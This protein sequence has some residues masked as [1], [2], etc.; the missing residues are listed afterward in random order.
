MATRLGRLYEEDF[1]AW[2][3]DQA[4]ALRRLAQARPNDA[5]DFVHLVEEV[6]DL[7][8]SE[9]DT[10]R[11]HVRT[12]IEHLLKLEHSA[13]REPRAG[14]T[15]SITHA[16][17]A[18]QDKLTPS[19]RRDLAANLDRLYEQARRQASVAMSVHGEAAA[20]AAL[21]SA[22]PYTLEHILDDDWL[23]PDPHGTD[24]RIGHRVG[25]R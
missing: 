12:I 17:I 24:A 15:I 13:A 10:V 23:P 4:K 21:P 22:W 14:W 5:V 18:L 6:Q 2:T 11:S 8:K 3:R 9:R 16:R 7:G 19:L 25:G 1:Y 20:A